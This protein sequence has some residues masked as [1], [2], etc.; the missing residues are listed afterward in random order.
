[1]RVLVASI[2]KNAGVADAR[3]AS[4]IE[5]ALR[6]IQI[7]PP[8]AVITDARV[9]AHSGL[10]LIE[11]LR[12]S[13]DSPCQTI[14][15]LVLTGLSHRSAIVGARDAG[16][17]GVI[18]KPVAPH[19]LIEKMTAAATNPRP[20]VRSLRYV[21][22]CRRIRA[23][24]RFMLGRRLDDEEDDPRL[25]TR[26]H[27]ESLA[28]H[29]DVLAACATPLDPRSRFQVRSIRNGAHQ[30]GEQALAVRDR[31]LSD[32]AGSLTG[33]VDACGLSGLLD[34]EVVDIH[35]A[36]MRNLTC[37]ERRRANRDFDVVSG[38]HKVVAR[39]LR[40]AGLAAGLPDPLERQAPRLL[41]AS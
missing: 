24:D 19:T 38:L 37:P 33:Y 32:T 7:H 4:T 12:R 15:A 29:V 34:G 22:P 26:A 36:T 10:K 28:V 23:D 25:T 6:E 20:F 13:S 30:V 40:D 2:L 3:L 16:A 41:A 35:V 27:C 1:M 17:H 5:D 18:A 14:P 9:G 39:R 8:A 11:W 31:P 21:G